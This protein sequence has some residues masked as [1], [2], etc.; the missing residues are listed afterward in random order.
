MKRTTR[1]ACLVTQVYNEDNEKAWFGCGVLNPTTM[2]IESSK[3]RVVIEG[4]SSDS[5]TPRHLQV[6]FTAGRQTTMLW[7]VIIILIGLV[8][9]LLVVLAFA[10][11]SRRKKPAGR[12][13]AVTPSRQTIQAESV[14]PGAP[15]A[16]P[17][18]AATAPVTA[19][20]S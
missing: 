11:L 2:V 19:T 6:A 16:R 7:N 5:G 9:V 15:V 10:M 12:T 20:T 3:V 17:P 14:Q 1:G 18:A 13:V 4:G 8:V